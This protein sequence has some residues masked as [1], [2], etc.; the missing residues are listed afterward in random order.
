MM[1]Q[2]VTFVLTFYDP[3]RMNQPDVTRHFASRT[4][5]EMWEHEWLDKI[6]PKAHS[7]Q[8][9]MITSTKERLT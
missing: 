4:E 9:F 8:K 5:L 6:H 1:E 3:D 7:V 2:H